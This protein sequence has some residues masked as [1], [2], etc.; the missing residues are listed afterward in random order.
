MIDLTTIVAAAV[1]GVAGV[2]IGS[3][4]PL[5]EWGI[6]KRRDRWKKRQAQ[7]TGW[8][9]TLQKCLKFGTD[10]VNTEAYLTLRP[11]IK[12]EYIAVLEKQKRTK[13]I[14]L[15]RKGLAA[16]DDNLTIINSAIERLAKMWHVD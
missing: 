9:N 3:F 6:E 16:G 15:G 13:V 4:K 2:F 10:F 14:K 8:R 5:I 7:I 11:Y 1:S 12:E